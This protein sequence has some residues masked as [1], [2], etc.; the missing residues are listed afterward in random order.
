MSKVSNYYIYKH[1]KWH[2]CDFKGRRVSKYFRWKWQA[3]L[4][5]RRVK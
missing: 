3:K 4:F 2:I 1:P 5:L